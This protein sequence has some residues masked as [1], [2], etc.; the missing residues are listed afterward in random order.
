MKKSQSTKRTTAQKPQGRA[1][2]A[3]KVST[4]TKAK[5]SQPRAR[6]VA[7]TTV[8]V[9]SPVAPEAVFTVASELADDALIEAEIMGDVLPHFIYQ[10]CDNRPACSA[11]VLQSGKCDHHKTTGLSVK[12]IN[13]VVRRMNKD[14]KSGAKI[15]INP[16][17]L[18]KE[19]VERDGEKGI[20][21][22]VFAENML[23]GNSAWGV[24]FEP[25]K[26]HGRNNTL[27]TNTFAVEKA[28]SKAERNA[29]RKL[30]PETLATKMIQTLIRS[31]QNVKALGAPPAVS[32]ETRT[33]PPPQPSTID[34]LM[35]LVRNGIRNAKTVDV[36]IEIDEKTQ[37]SD[38]FSPDFK[39][40][41]H[42]LASS[43]VDQL[44]SK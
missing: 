37:A 20:E 10:F 17:Y 15:R 27:Y 9:S 29:K 19:E 14:P 8:V 11:E 4:P 36:A 43:R 35:Q 5:K 30:I 2:K 32:H 18:M 44:D 13:E 12:G 42:A 39:K 3:K 22:S 25:W 1:K 6:K 28:L 16:A 26:K 38:K 33:V 41:I 40:E 34:E 31:P 7:K 21:I 24:K 23:D